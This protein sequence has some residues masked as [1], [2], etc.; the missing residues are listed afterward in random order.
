MDFSRVGTL[1]KNLVPKK[2]GY[3]KWKIGSFMDGVVRE[4]SGF[5]KEPGCI[6]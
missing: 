2:A 1:E 5:Q 6:D 3:F 4:N